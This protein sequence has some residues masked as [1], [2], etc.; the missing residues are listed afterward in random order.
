VNV[1]REHA[2]LPTI[3]NHWHNL[4]LDEK[5]FLDGLPGN[6]RHIETVA[7]SSLYYLISRVFNAKLTPEGEAPSYTAAINKIAAQL[8]SVGD[9]GPHKLF[10]LEK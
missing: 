9:F 3:N 1:M 8:P 2:D 6:I 4:Y 7:F 10:I 5:A